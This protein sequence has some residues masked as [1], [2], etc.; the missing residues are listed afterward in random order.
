MKPLRLFL[1][2]CAF[3]VSVVACSEIKTTPD[4]E[5]LLLPTAKVPPIAEIDSAIARWGNSH[6]ARYFVELDEQTQEKRWIVR[7]IVADGVIRTAQ[8]LVMDAEGNWGEPMNLAPEEAQAYTVDAILERVRKDALGNGPAPVDL[9]AFFDPSLGY[10]NAVHAE[11]LPVYTEDGNLLLDRQYSYDLAVKVKA[12]LEDTFVVD[13]DPIFTYI[14]SGGLQASCDTSRIFPDGSA[15]YTDDCR[16][17]AFQ[18]TLPTSLQAALDSLRS[19]FASL[20]DLRVESDQA[21]RLIILGTGEGTPDA[22]NSDAAWAL[23]NEIHEILS[24]PLGLGLTMVYL[25]NGDLIGFDVL[26]KNLIPADLRA[27]G[28]LHGALLSPDGKALAY[29][30]DRGLSILEL[31]TG[32]VTSILNITE[33]G[34]YLP[35]AWSGSNNILVTKVSNTGGELS[36]H[37]W[38]STEEKVWRT[39][40]LPESTT[41]YGCDNGVAWSPTSTQLAISG[42][43]YAHPCNM[44]PGLTVVDIQAGTAQRIV[45]PAIK[46]GDESGGTVTAGAHSPA[47]SMD[48]AW[49]AFGLDQDALAPLTFP[50]RLYRVRPDGSDLTPITNNSQGIAAYPLW[51]SDGSL[52]YSLSGESAE[53][54]GIYHYIPAENRHDLIIPGSNIIPLSISTDGEFLVYAEDGM[55]RIWSFRLGEVYGE[56]SGQDGVTPSFVGWVKSGE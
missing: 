12:L 1:I 55:L 34:Y 37:G 4:Q 15:A 14:Q 44:S 9:E 3:V 43:G 18:L 33:G 36:E 45:A 46:I 56:V 7:L 39:L 40:P 29:S 24:E 17:K 21:K 53:T 35:R 31:G 28:K 22:A 11:A 52:Y 30:D 41:S 47:W 19:S 5:V 25:S 27:S 54:D 16:G 38:V 26:N 2:L 13:K 42:L 48:G 23:A 51:A 10:P 32:K 20:D 50:T 6:T 49:I 8:R